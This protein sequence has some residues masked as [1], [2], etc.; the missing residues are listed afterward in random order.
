MPKWL[1]RLLTILLTWWL[2]ALFVQP[3]SVINPIAH[4]RELAGYVVIISLIS[5]LA[6]LWPRAW[7]IWLTT[8]FL[9]MIVG[10][11][12][13]LPLKQHFGLTWFNTYVQTFNT[14]TRRFLQV[15]GVDVPATLSMTLI[16]ALVAFLLLITVVLQLY[17]GAV[18]I[19]L[20][21]LLAVHVFNGSDLTTQFFQLAVVTGLLA[22]LHLYHTRWRA[23]LIGSLSI[24]GLTLG[25]MWLSTS[26]PLNDWLANIS[27]PARERLNQRGFYASLEAY[28]NGSGRTGFTENSRVLGGPVY[29]DPTPVFTATSREAHYYRVEVDSFYTGTGWRPSTFQTQAA[30]LDGAIMRDPS[31]QVDYGKQRQ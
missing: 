23:F 30:P 19:V 3:F 21:Y 20:S 25:L 9:S 4:P 7:P 15:G 8:A 28:A 14:A 22:V 24:V 29:D 2:L 16:V 26:T 5:Y 17:P 6:A 27:V 18:A 1:Q 10:L 13:I 11:W 12:A 31:A